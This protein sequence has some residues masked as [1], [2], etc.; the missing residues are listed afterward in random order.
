[1]RNKFNA[2]AAEVGGNEL[3]QRI[4]LGF[5]V[6]GNQHSHV[7]NQLEELTRFV[8]RLA[9]AEVVDVRVEIMNLK[10][11]TWAPASD[12]GWRS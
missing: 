1:V 9:L 2:S 4:E 3:W 8:E 10:D 6:C 12:L 7:Q 5:S 11:M